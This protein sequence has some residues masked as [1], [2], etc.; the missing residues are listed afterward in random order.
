MTG[1]L[2]SVTLHQVSSVVF[3]HVQL[4]RSFYNQACTA[5][6]LVPCKNA[7]IYTYIPVLQRGRKSQSTFSLHLC[8]KA[9]MSLTIFY[10]QLW[11]RQD[12]HT[13][14]YQGPA[15]KKTLSK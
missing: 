10:L 3:L 15:S 7:L 4:S 1:S 6:Q 9:V 11:Q 2:F 13:V 12:N 5:S 8:Q 14:G